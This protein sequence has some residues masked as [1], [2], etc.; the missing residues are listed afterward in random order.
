MKQIL[1][2]IS[3][4][5]FSSPL[6]IQLPYWSNEKIY[7]DRVIWQWIKLIRVVDPDFIRNKILIFH[8]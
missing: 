7:I 4:Y 8:K 6:G 3:D 2:E 5:S 1:E